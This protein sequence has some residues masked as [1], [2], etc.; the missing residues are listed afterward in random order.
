[1]TKLLRPMLAAT[2]ED[3]TALRFPLYAS[4]KLDGVR[5]LITKQGVFSRSL[6]PIPNQAVQTLFTSADRDGLD[7][8]FILGKVTAED[9]CRQTVSAVMSPDKPA[10]G[11]VYHVFDYVTTR[12]FTERAPCS[13]ERAGDEVRWKISNHFGRPAVDSLL[14]GT[15]NDGRE[16]A[17][18]GPR[19]NYGPPTIRTLQARSGD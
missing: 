14:G 11:L 19:R 3:F 7:G 5:A 17:G 8:E 18:R 2:C 12:P 6:K 1:M 4:L 10:T 16:N 13:G 15:R 9:V